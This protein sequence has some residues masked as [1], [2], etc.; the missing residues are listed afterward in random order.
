MIHICPET[1]CRR[2]ILPH[3]LVFPD[4]FLT[5]LDKRLHT[6]SLDLLLAVK[7][8]LFLYFKLYR[9]SMSI[10]ARFTWNHVSFHSTVSWDHI[11]DNTGQHMTD[12]R[13]AV[14]C[15]RS[16]IKGIS[17]SLLT[18]VHTFFKNMV[19]FPKLL[20]L[21]FHGQQNSGSYLLSDTQ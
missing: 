9:K 11:L 4:T 2:K 8:K 1:N 10:P 17:F 13:L 16:V 7:T 19:F 3:S 15:W 6:V 14:G 12:M 20:D 18:A 5:L 21:F